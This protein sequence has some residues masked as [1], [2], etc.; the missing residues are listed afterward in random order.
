GPELLTRVVRQTQGNGSVKSPAVF[1]PIPW[2]EWETLLSPD[3][4]A[5]RSRITART[6]GVHLWHE[7]WRRA[8]INRQ[9]TVPSPS[10]YGELLRRYPAGPNGAVSRRGEGPAAV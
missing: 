3:P 10:Y 4:R 2:W 5:C 6:Y 1:C 9:A 8:G 7:M